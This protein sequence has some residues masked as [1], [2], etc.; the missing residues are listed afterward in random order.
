MMYYYK[1]QDFMA[2]F[3]V[4]EEISFCHKNNCAL[5]GWQFCKLQSFLSKCHIILSD[6]LRKSLNS[7]HVEI[8][9][10]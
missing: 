3:K 1:V 9:L 2:S 8:V 7:T 10:S 5:Q 6:L 4:F